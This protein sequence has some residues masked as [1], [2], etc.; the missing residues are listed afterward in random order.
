MDVNACWRL[1]VL[2]TGHSRYLH[3]ILN[4]HDRWSSHILDHVKVKPQIVFPDW[5]RKC[6]QVLKPSFFFSSLPFR[7]SLSLFLSQEVCWTLCIQISHYLMKPVTALVF[8]VFS[9]VKL[10]CINLSTLI[11]S[12]L[13]SHNP[14]AASATKI[15]L[16]CVSQFVQAPKYHWVSRS[17]SPFSDDFGIV[18][19]LK[20]S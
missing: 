10:S 20:C 18:G 19:C 9:L 11:S 4:I 17:R 7:F 1:Q 13:T 12:N 6:L 14:T 3:P 16:A 2:K 8:H 5:T 15:C